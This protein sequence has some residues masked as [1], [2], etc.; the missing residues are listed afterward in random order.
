MT[1]PHK[2]RNPGVKRPETRAWRGQGTSPRDL[3]I[4]LEHACGS[5]RWTVHTRRGALK[6]STDELRSFSR[7]A[8]KAL[9]KLDLVLDPDFNTVQWF[10]LLNELMRPLREA[11]QERPH[12]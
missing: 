5:D 7:F 8:F 12:A 6:V 1:M 11:M 3:I 10:A 9:L 4:G 2:R